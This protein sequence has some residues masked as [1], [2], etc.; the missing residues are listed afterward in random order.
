M[1]PLWRDQ[2]LIAISP[3]HLSMLRLRGRL[4]RYHIVKQHKQEI[5]AADNIQPTWQPVFDA[6]EARL[7]EPVWQHAVAKIVISNAL[8]TY[9]LLPWSETILNAD[10]ES[11][12][13]RIKMKDVF[14]AN[15][16]N[17]EVSLAE[18]RYGHPRLA[19]AMDR[20]MLKELRQMAV[21]SKLDI[22]SIQPH[23]VSALN[24]W[25]KKLLDEQA[26]FVMMDGK[27][28]STVYIEKGELKSVRLA[29]V[30]EALTGEVLATNM[31]RERLMNGDANQKVNVYLFAPKK[32]KVS[33]SVDV[34]PKLKRLHLPTNYAINPAGFL[35]SAGL[36]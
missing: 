7:N 35:A 25:Q 33:N 32:A 21:K 6:L 24:Y 31:Q 2:V 27:K 3:S 13:V 18:Q 19:C 22:H 36:V 12:L 11:Q 15:N 9:Q 10:E 8:T 29:Q 5:A 17:W 16:N 4:G 34:L 26:Y 1:L 23:L 28:L 20:D 14:G 30:N